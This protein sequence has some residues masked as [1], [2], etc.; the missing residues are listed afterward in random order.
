MKP[1]LLLE[2]KLAPGHRR[3]TGHRTRDRGGLCQRRRAVSSSPT[4]ATRPAPRHAPKSR[5]RALRPGA[6]R[7]T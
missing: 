2:G 7:S 6:S 4:S 3:R 5:R 1:V